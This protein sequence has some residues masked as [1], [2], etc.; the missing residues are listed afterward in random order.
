M[1]K[2]ILQLVL[3]FSVLIL[4]AACGGSNSS[5]DAGATSEPTVA[6]TMPSASFAAVSQSAGVITET[7]VVS[8]TES[9]G[10][11]GDLDRGAAAYTK[12]KCGDCHGANGEGVT[13]KGNAIAGTTLSAEDFETVLRTGGGLGNEHIFGRSAISPGGMTALYEYVQSLK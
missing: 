11:T 4:L 1:R 2:S 7:L 5:T 8:E 3:L 6:P 12:N 13:D 10:S 9:S